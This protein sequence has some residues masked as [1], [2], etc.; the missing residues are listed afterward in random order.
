[1]WQQGAS[2]V[3][4]A[5]LPAENASPDEQQVRGSTDAV[6]WT[7]S[8]M[9]VTITL[10]CGMPNRTAS[11]STGATNSQSPRAVRQ[12]CGGFP[13]TIMRDGLCIGV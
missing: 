6:A 11:A 1:M 10:G 7:L 3:G 12:D 8:P 4:N 5:Q 9:P 2:A 13:L